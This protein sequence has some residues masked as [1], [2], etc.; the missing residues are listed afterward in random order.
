MEL[1][2][3]D[4]ELDDRERLKEVLTRLDGN[5]IRLNGYSEPARVRASEQKDNFPKRHDWDSYFR[6]A[7]NMD[8]KKPGERP[9]TIHISN[10]P[11]RWF[12]P[13]H[14]ENEE[15]VKPSESI[16]RRIFEKFGSVRVVDIPI[17][18]LYRK[19]MKSHMTGMKTFSFDQELYFEGY[20]ENAFE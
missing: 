15:N 3:L 16:F 4:A 17:C 6:D 13:R 14:M 9:D 10:L 18:D 19:D 11:I 7:R 8:E 5:S 2:R 1:C 20:A 12:C